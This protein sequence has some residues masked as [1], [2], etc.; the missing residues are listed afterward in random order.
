MPFA[1]NHLRNANLYVLY[2]DIH[3]KSTTYMKHTARSV[4][5]WIAVTGLFLCGLLVQGIPGR[6][7][8]NWIVKGYAFQGDDSGW[9]IKDF[10]RRNSFTENIPYGRSSRRIHVTNH[11]RYIDIDT[12]GF[13]QGILLWDLFDYGGRHPSGFFSYEVLSQM[14]S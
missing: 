2:F 7:V 12:V 11:A 13:F 3:A 10:L 14:I 1:I 6:T 5:F 4:M 9:T 8:F